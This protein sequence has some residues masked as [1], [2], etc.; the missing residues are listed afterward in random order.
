[1]IHTVGI[2]EIATS[3]NSEDRIITHALGSCVAVTF[4]CKTTKVAG[5]IHIALP[6]RP[7]TSTV[8]T[9]VG[10]YAD[11]G[12]KYIIETL[13]QQ[14]NFNFYSASIHIIGGANP[15]KSKDI[16]MIGARNLQAVRNYF[17]LRNVPF[18]ELDVG[19][20]VSRT[21]ELTVIDGLISIRKQP[22][23]I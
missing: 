4:Y 10:Y 5:M 6:S 18:I 23:I 16:F 1:M 21:V 7:Q 13:H 12:L 9:K 8:T 11:E 15:S 20:T 3:A 2:G 14:Y 19:G 17:S 22:L